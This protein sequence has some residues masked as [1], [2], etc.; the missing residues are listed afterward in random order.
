L[1]DYLKG[2][3]WVDE[4]VTHHQKLDDINKGFDDMHVSQLSPSIITYLPLQ[5]IPTSDGARAKRRKDEI[6]IKNEANN[7]A[8]DCIRCVV[9]MGFDKSEEKN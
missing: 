5:P 4:F 2:T 3:L 8:G 1:V 6:R 7:Q 9:D